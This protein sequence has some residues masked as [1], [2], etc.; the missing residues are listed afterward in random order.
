MHS[1]RENNLPAC[2]SCSFNNEEECFEKLQTCRQCVDLGSRKLIDAS[3]CKVAVPAP[4]PPPSLI[5]RAV[6]VFVS[7]PPTLFAIFIAS[8]SHYK[9]MAGSRVC[10]LGGNIDSS[11]IECCLWRGR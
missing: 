8:L 2:Y 1:Q 3:T 11:Y 4:Y 7:C 5:P 10:V 9:R 6:F